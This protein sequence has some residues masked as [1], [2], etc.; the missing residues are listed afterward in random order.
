MKIKY[1]AAVFG[2]L[3]FSSPSYG[4]TSAAE[5]V[6]TATEAGD[7]EIASSRLAL[8]K[9]QSPDVKKFAQQMID[10]HT[11][12]AQKLQAVTLNAGMPP[13]T[14]PNKKHAEDMKKLQAAK[15]SEIDPMYVAIQ[16]EA[17]ETAIQLFSD[18]AKNGDDPKLKQ[19]AADTLP[20][21]QTHLA[22][23]KTIMVSK[24]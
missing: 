4:A 13:L 18:Y 17:H 8:E 23:V 6:K 15:P 20:T 24:M 1:I 16:R 14:K 2:A 3:I 21:L 5:F 12:A 19:Y 22:H 11:A 7:F 9:S 10:D